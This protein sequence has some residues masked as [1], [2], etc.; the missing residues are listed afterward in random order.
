[1][2]KQECRSHF[3][4]NVRDNVLT[5]DILAL[6][7]ARIARNMPNLSTLPAILSDNL[8]TGVGLLSFL[9]A[10][11]TSARPRGRAMPSKACRSWSGAH[12]APWAGPRRRKLTEIVLHIA[13]LKP[14]LVPSADAPW[15]QLLRDA[16]Q[17]DNALLN[18]VTLRVDCLPAAMICDGLYIQR[19]Y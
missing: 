16:L 2:R 13:D 7:G 18:C 15:C 10:I 4:I 11:L 9:A 17:N 19:E 14:P 12:L 1:M 8:V 5:D 6:L 3:I